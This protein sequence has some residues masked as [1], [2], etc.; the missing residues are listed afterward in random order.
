MDGGFAELLR[1]LT[2][3]TLNEVSNRVKVIGNGL[4]AKA[5]RFQ[6]DGASSSERV[7]NAWYLTAIGR[8]NQCA[9]DPQNL[10]TLYA[11]RIT[12][13][14]LDQTAIIQRL[15]RRRQRGAQARLELLPLWRPSRYESH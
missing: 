7:E 15:G 11:L 5:F 6:G 10:P 13:L 12:R 9:S 14:P 8:R 2:C 3:S 4:N 1:K